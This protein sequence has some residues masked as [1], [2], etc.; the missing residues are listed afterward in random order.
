MPCRTSLPARLTGLPG[1]ETGLYPAEVAGT[2]IWVI[3][4]ALALAAAAAQP[5][6]KLRARR[7]LAQAGLAALCLGGAA[8]IMLAVL[9]LTQSRAAWLACGL[10]VAAL[11][12]LAVRRW[13][14][15]AF[16][17]VAA[18]LGTAALTLIVVGPLRLLQVALGLG[19][20]SAQVGALDTVEG[21][22][23]MWSRAIY[24]LRDFPFTGLGLNQFRALI[25]LLYPLALFGPGISIPHVHN[26][27]LQVGVELGLPAVVAF[28]ALWVGAAAMLVRAWRMVGRGA[29][30]DW[31]LQAF[32]R[33]L[34][35]GLG[36]GLLAFFVFG[37]TDT[38][39]IGARPGVFWWLLLGLIASLYCRA[40]QSAV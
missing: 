10:V 18:G 29:P 39:S 31:L 3:P 17:G 24:V 21:R 1:A 16:G 12:L 37:V 22:L 26:L 4:A 5:R 34:A 25:H 6:G 13:P 2:L 20:A 7:G 33:P 38:I 35:A 11:L 40:A 23:D 19:R 30:D 15:L 9:F 27:W 28:A 8:L 14:V 36:G 32:G